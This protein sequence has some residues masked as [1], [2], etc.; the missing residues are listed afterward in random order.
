WTGRR[1][2][3]LETHP[4]PDR[5][6]PIRILRHAIGPGQPAADLLVSPDHCLYLDGGLVPARLLVNGMTVTKAHTMGTVT[7]HHL[8]LERHGLLIAEGVAAESYLDTGNRGSLSDA[9]DP[10]PDF[11]GEPPKCWETDA[12]APLLTRPGQVRP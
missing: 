1:T 2:V 11:A 4:N 7:Y 10:Y 12:C 8:E 3:D 6:A 9:V 5:A